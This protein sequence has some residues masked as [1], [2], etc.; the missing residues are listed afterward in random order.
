VGVIET[1]RPAST[2]TSST[3]GSAGTGSPPMDEVTGTGLRHRT[4]STAGAV[5]EVRAPLL[6]VAEESDGS[7]AGG[8]VTTATSA[9]TSASV[10]AAA[11]TA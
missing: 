5:V 8:R 1:T 6:R 3:A 10:P 7:A 11:S 4:A 2:T 9:A